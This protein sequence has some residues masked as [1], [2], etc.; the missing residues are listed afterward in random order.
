L[1]TEIAPGTLVVPDDYVSFWDV[2]A[3]YDD[4]VQHI[5]PSLDP[6]L[7]KQLVQAAKA[8][9]VLRY[10]SLCSVDNYGHG[11]T[12]EPPTFEDIRRTQESNARVVRNVLQAVA[13][14]ME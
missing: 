12:K 8:Q 11:I 14:R 10:A 3:Y 7:R 2:P 5:T 13:E 4:Q 9:G 1:Q 6:D